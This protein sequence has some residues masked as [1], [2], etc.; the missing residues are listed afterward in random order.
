VAPVELSASPIDLDSLGVRIF[1]PFDAGAQTTMIAGGK[2]KTVITPEDQSWI[3][4]MFVSISGNTGL[5]SQDALGAVVDQRKRQ[6]ELPATEDRPTGSLVYEL[7]RVDKLTL[8]G[9]PASRSYVRLVAPTEESVPV[10]G[11]T[12]IN[13]APGRFLIVQLDCS[14]AVFD[15]AKVVYETICAAAQFP[16]ENELDTDRT[17]S[18]MAGRTFLSTITNA[19]LDAALESEPQFVRIFMPAATQSPGDAREIGYQKLEIRK[20]QLGELDPDRP[21]DSWSVDEREFGYIVRTDARMLQD[22]FVFDSRA[23]FFLSNDRDRES[24]AVLVEQKTGASVIKSRQTVVRSG[25]RMTTSTERTGFPAESK[26]FDL[27]EGQYLSA[28]E[29]YMLP[30]I[31]ANKVDPTAPALFDMAFYSYDGSRGTVSLRRETFDRSDDGHW[32][33]QTTPGEGQPSW[34]STYT[35]DGRLISRLV[36]PLQVM[37]PT[38]AER[39]RS[40]WKGKDLPID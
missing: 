16:N 9:K 19:D 24:W 1:L 27:P 32:V 17:A 11:Y 6:L 7:E 8:A 39:I 5:T 35:A 18:I 20:G 38:T 23:I 37:E 10:T 22:Q 26:Q 12:L 4:Q 30:R 40:L 31:V 29:R 3:I 21:K 28:V 36:P 13:T 2:S 14:S 33:C 34:T 25:S 15:R